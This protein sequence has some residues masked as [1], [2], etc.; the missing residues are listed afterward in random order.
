M[1]AVKRKC[2]NSYSINCH[3]ITEP[4]YAEIF[5]PSLSQNARTTLGNLMDLGVRIGGTRAAFYFYIQLVVKLLLLA[6]PYLIL[7]KYECLSG[8]IL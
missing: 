8:W 4:Y 1:D 5:L 3:K 2:A 6:P 7:D